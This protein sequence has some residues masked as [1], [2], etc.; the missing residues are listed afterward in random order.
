MPTRRYKTRAAAARGG[1]GRARRMSSPSFAA[2]PGPSLASA[3]LDYAQSDGREG[4]GGIF[5][6][7][8]A[9]RQA[10]QAVPAP[11]P[12]AGP[13]APAGPAH[14]TELAGSLLTLPTQWKGTHPTDNAPW[15]TQGSTA[16]DI[17]AKA[18]TIVGAPEPVQIVRHGSA[19]GGRSVYLDRLSDPDSE[20]DY[21]AGHI[22]NPLPVGTVVKRRGGRIAVVSKDHPAPHVH[23]DRINR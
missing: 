15:N 12:G 5:D 19:Q 20:P 16:T 11:M 7:L 6:A 14:T 23:W 13:D 3:L 17:M 22:D 18:G 21:W 10:A 9:R 8:S 4:V 1:P 2:A